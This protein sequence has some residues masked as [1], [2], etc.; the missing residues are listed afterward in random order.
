[1]RP[2]RTE[3]IFTVFIKL[4]LKQNCNVYVFTCY[5]VVFLAV[6]SSTAHHLP[7]C[8]FQCHCFEVLF[9]LVIDPTETLPTKLPEVTEVNNERKVI[10]L[11]TVPPL[12]L[13]WQKSVLI[14]V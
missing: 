9:F 3:N 1:M 12:L 13:Y 2:A 6:T 8:S 5:L 11:P 7:S 14:I 4:V 10:F